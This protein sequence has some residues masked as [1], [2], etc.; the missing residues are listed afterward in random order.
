M[1]RLQIANTARDSNPQYWRSTRTPPAPRPLTAYPH[2][3]LILS[4]AAKLLDATRRKRARTRD[5]TGKA[6]AIKTGSRPSGFMPRGASSSLR[7]IALL[8]AASRL[9]PPAVRHKVLIVRHLITTEQSQHPGP[10]PARVRTEPLLVSSERTFRETPVFR[11]APYCAYG[12]SFPCATGAC[13][14]KGPDITSC[15][16]RA[17]AN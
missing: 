7:P 13:L 9:T 16:G 8:A 4:T 11:Q 14:T 5:M 15:Q 6:N 12:S 17:L 2:F 10:S 1:E 3:R